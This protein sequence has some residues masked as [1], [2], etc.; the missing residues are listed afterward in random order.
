MVDGVKGSREVEKA[1][2]MKC[3]RQK[4]INPKNNDYTVYSGNAQL[5][6][7]QC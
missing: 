7:C 2:M 6:V 5:K 4:T 3:S 1:D